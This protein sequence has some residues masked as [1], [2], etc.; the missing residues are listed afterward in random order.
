MRHQDY[1]DE[2]QKIQASEAFKAK[3][4]QMLLAE[5]ETPTPEEPAKPKTAWFTPRRIVATAAAVVVLAGGVVAVRGVFSSLN[6][7]MATIQQGQ[8]FFNEATAATGAASVPAGNQPSGY[9]APQQPQAPQQQAAPKMAALSPYEG[10]PNGDSLPDLPAAAQAEEGQQKELA[11]LQLDDIQNYTNDWALQA[12]EEVPFTTLPVYRKM[13]QQTAT[14]YVPSGLSQQQ[15]EEVLYE[16]AA[17][18]GLYVQRVEPQNIEMETGGVQQ[19]LY[20]VTGTV[21]GGTTLTV[22]R[23]GQVQVQF[24]QP[25][26]PAAGQAPATGDEMQ[27]HLQYLQAL[28]TE[29]TPLL[30]GMQTPTAMV[31]HQQS[32]AGAQWCYWVYDA[33]GTAEGALLNR[34]LA[35]VQFAFNSDGLLTELNMRRAELLELVAETPVL[36]VAEA[37]T[38]LLAGQGAALA[39]AQQPPTKQNIAKVDLVYDDDP[40]A[41]YIVPFYKFYV[42]VPGEESTA[43]NDLKT[44]QEW[45]V[46]AV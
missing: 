7:S 20:T 17:A 23:S 34:S 42:E 2:L 31:T 4:K 30:S 13:L 18:L 9:F 44:Y 11:Q 36:T 32:A 19:G 46:P 45:L 27:A 43:D 24:G 12:G 6:S 33:G 37:E 39:G 3:T 29:Y 40:T 41:Q 1:K 14:G 35:G 21:A 38:I 16:Q 5:L 8:A 26:N 10:M 22:W 15:M 25:V 28:I